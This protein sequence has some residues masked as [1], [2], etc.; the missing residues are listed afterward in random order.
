MQM[1]ASAETLKNW[2]NYK[3]SLQPGIISVLHTYSEQKDLHYHTHMILSWGG[4]NK[5]RTLQQIKG[6]QVS[7]DYIKKKFQGIYER[8]LIVLFDSGLL[9]HNFKDLSEFKR[10]IRRINSKNWIIHFEDP[11]NTPEAVIRYI[12]RYSKKACLSE[13]KITR[14]EDEIIAFKYKDNKNKDFNGLPIEKEK[15]LN[16]RDF[17]PLLLQHV[18][19]PYF[20]MVRYYGIYSNRGH[21]PREYFDENEDIPLNWQSL[22]QSETGEDPL[23]CKKCKITKIYSHSIVESKNGTYKYYRLGLRSD[24]HETVKEKV[25]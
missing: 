14:M 24:S 6:K 10:F 11:M 9:Q 13:Y 23:V 1:Q 25:A 21:L 7:Y 3:Y 17:F 4:I 5:D 15:V 12:G 8:R 20:R 22:Q 19:L 16:Y 18:P 2:M